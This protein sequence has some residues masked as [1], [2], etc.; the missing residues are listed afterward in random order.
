[1]IDINIMSDAS[2]IIKYDNIEVPL[3]IQSRRLSSYRDMRALCHWHKD[4]ECIHILEG[5]MKYDV[6]GEV[7]LL[8][9][10]DTVIVNSSQLHF[11]YAN[12]QREC[13]FLCVI[14]HPSLLSAN[15]FLYQKYVE[16]VLGNK[17]IPCWYLPTSHEQAKAA[18]VI[19]ERIRHHKESMQSSGEFCIIGDIMELWSLVYQCSESIPD[20]SADQADE[21]I[22]LQKKMVSFVHDHYRDSIGLE[23]IAAAGIVSRSKC[24]R[25]FQRYLKQSPVAFLNDYR[26]EISCN[27]LKE[28]SYSITDI[29]LFCG[30]NHSSYFSR[31]FQ[32]R[33][34]MT[35]YRYRKIYSKEPA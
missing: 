20:S 31:I 22:R 7:M 9:A 4:I 15:D 8:Q 6:N 25:I 32:K 29:A 1:M 3:A 27:L 23:D 11:G 33:Y 28:T 10:G 35:P 14:F 19:F 16:P 24:C 18:H 13:R 21:E 5:E 26:L 30:Y 12:E 2:E 34:G 17:S